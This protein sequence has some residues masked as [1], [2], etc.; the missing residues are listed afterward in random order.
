MGK[1]IALVAL[2]FAGFTAC[3]ARAED[4]PVV[5]ELFTSEGCSSCPPADALLAELARRPGV[6]AL[7]FH[8]DYWNR[9][10]WKDP[11]SSHDA[12]ERQRRYAQLLG[13][14][15]I[16]TPQIVIDGSREAVGSD[17]SAVERAIST[18]RRNHGG[19]PV[20]LAL[21][22]RKVRITVGGGPGAGSVLLIGFDRRHVS[23]VARGENSGRTLSHVDVVRSIDEVGRLAGNPVELESP[24]DRRFDQIAVLAQAEDGRIIG[25]AVADAGPR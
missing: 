6:L 20:T 5:V 3:G 24:L 22:D 8:V 18:A 12:T 7:S 1:A 17:R 10:G 19:L 13:S 21:D 4:R 2:L 9:L 23:A 14:G 25:A 11:F 15:T 16:Y